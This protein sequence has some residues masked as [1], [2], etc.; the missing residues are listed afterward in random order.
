MTHAAVAPNLYFV[1]RQANLLK[2]GKIARDLD[3]NV[4]VYLCRSGAGD[5]LMANRTYTKINSVEITTAL[6]SH[7]W[8]ITGRSVRGLVSTWCSWG[9]III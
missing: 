9:A 5:P 4:D 2:L 7:E 8:N 1:T 3:N 6:T